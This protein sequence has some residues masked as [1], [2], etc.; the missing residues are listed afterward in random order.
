MAYS[1]EKIITGYPGK[2]P[3]KGVN[4]LEILD[5]FD[6]KRIEQK[7][8]DEFA[9]RNQYETCYGWEKDGIPHSPVAERLDSMRTYFGF[10]RKEL[11]QAVERYES[12][13]AA[14]VDFTTAYKNCRI[15]LSQAIGHKAAIEYIQQEYD[16][17][18]ED[19]RKK[20]AEE[21]I[22]WEKKREADRQRE[23]DEFEER[24]EAA[25]EEGY[26]YYP[27]FRPASLHE[28][29]VR[30]R[31]GIKGSDGKPLTQ[32][33]FAKYIECPINKYVEAEKV[34][35]WG[36]SD[37]EESPVEDEL[38][39][40]LILRCNANPYWLYDEECEAFCGW[41]ELGEDAVIRG[42]EPCIF[43]Y[44]DVILRW[45]K[46]GKPRSTSWEDGRFGEFEYAGVG[47]YGN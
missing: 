24:M 43:A 39:E 17:L 6:P 38:L 1:N 22:A 44:P 15:A 40:K 18:G 45:I 2:D 10:R 26:Y 3:V 13:C 4:W 35:K 5:A 9:R 41:E 33:D 42:D 34:D 16:S 28:K 46:N 12:E 37:K 32:R 8:L 25:A 11:E 19:G 23:E 31:K 21:Y 7:Y 27:E 14:G 47:Y 20:Q 29:I 30:V 36:R